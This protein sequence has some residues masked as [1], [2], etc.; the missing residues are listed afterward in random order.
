[1]LAASHFLLTICH[2][3]LA[4]AKQNHLKS[5]DIFFFKWEVFYTLP[6]KCNIL[7]PGSLKRLFRDA[8][9]VLNNSGRCDDLTSF[10]TQTCFGLFVFFSELDACLS[11]QPNPSL[12]TF[13]P[14]SQI[15]THLGG[16]LIISA[17][18]HCGFGVFSSSFFLYH[19][20]MRRER[21]PS[22]TESELRTSAFLET[23]C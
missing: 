22:K 3:Y 21:H 13:I 1:M 17:K 4:S 14:L 10:K 8:T 19:S 18:P 9:I 23:T 2:Y 5:V 7:S 15:M 20:N 11:P 6:F 16:L 12:M